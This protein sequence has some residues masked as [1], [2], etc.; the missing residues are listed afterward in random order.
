MQEAPVL[1]PT[2]SRPVILGP[3][4]CL[5]GKNVLSCFVEFIQ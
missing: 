4:S 1:E 3:G 2:G 5:D